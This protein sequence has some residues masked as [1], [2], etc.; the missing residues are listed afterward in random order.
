MIRSPFGFHYTLTESKI[1]L[2]SIILLK[3]HYGTNYRDY[4]VPVIGKEC[5]PV[6]NVAGCPGY[7]RTL[8]IPESSPGIYTLTKA[9]DP[10]TV[11]QSGKM[12]RPASHRPQQVQALRTPAAND[13]EGEHSPAP[14]EVAQSAG[15]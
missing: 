9:Y 4:P 5:H 2:L 15:H 10:L 11:A 7:T 13:T 1:R 12:L 3:I 14:C 8:W 6:H